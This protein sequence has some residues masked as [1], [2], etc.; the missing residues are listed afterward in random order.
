[1][2]IG[3]NQNQSGAD[4]RANF[5]RFKKQKVEQIKYRKYVTEQTT[6]DRK[7]P[8]VK[9][10]L[11][12]KYLETAKKYFG[13]PYAKR[14][15]SPGE[16]LYDAP[17]F[18][19]CCALTRQITYDMREDTTKDDALAKDDTKTSDTT[20]VVTH[21][22]SKFGINLLGGYDFT[23]QVPTYGVSITKQ[24]FGPFTIGLF[25][26]NNSTAGASFGLTF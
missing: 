25:G 19:D 14:Y 11:R 24:V 1:M 4:L 5:E 9:K 26:L 16:P 18:L 2:W 15:F 13:V 17:I 3:N 6:V 12:E 21:D 8:A 23:K 20:K 10:R 7:D 22:I